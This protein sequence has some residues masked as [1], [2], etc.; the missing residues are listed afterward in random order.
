M[1]LYQTHDLWALLNQRFFPSNS[2]SF[3]KKM[4]AE[5]YMILREGEKNTIKIEEGMGAGYFSFIFSSR[6]PLFTFS[7]LICETKSCEV[8]LHSD[9]LYSHLQ[10]AFSPRKLQQRPE[11]DKEREV[12][13]FLIRSPLAFT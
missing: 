7:S 8:L 12:K 2:I 4:Q 13:V 5:N 10:I 3:G 1:L 9:F 11:G 6:N